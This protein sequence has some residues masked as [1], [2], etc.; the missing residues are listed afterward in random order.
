MVQMDLL[1]ILAL[2]ATVCVLQA[3][4][5]E[6]LTVRQS[7]VVLTDTCLTEDDISSRAI[8]EDITKTLSTIASELSGQR[9]KLYS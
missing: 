6:A 3:S 2:T 5:H 7:A 1:A 8:D 9:S 4:A